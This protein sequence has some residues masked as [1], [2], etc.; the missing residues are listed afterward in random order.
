MQHDWIG[1][2]A[3]DGEVLPK[4]LFLFD[5]PGMIP[6]FSHLFLLSHSLSFFVV[7]FFLPFVSFFSVALS[8]PLP[9]SFSF[10]LFSVPGVHFCPHRFRVFLL[11]PPCV[12]CNRPH[13]LYVA[14]IHSYIV[15]YGSTMALHRRDH[16]HRFQFRYP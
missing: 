4:S 12:P 5:F 13:I 2:E 1:L 9:F 10:L 3:I 16:R 8:S 6:L 11:F 15:M 14:C 7:S